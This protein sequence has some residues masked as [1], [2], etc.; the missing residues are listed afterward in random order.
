[1]PH[2]EL[3]APSPEQLALLA[4]S[5]STVTCELEVQKLLRVALQLASVAYS[6]VSY[7]VIMIP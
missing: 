4:L 3:E 5:L 6:M 2:Q 7:K 1:M